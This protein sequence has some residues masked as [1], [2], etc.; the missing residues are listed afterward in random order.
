MKKQNPSSSGYQAAPVNRSIP[1][2][3]QQQTANTASWNQEAAQDGQS[4]SGD[5]YRSEPMQSKSFRLLQKLTEGI[6]D[7]MGQTFIFDD[8]VTFDEEHDVCMKLI[9]P[10][11]PEF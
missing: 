1:V 10:A 4:A 7:G 6:E 9:F 2:Q 5:Y 11:P 8:F 3:Q